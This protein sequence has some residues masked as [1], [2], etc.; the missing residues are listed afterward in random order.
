MGVVED[1]SR[2]ADRLSEADAVSLISHIDAD[3]ITSYSII[4]QALTREGIPV[5][6]DVILWIAIPGIISGVFYWK[7]WHV[8]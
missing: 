5:K 3:G 7:K 4:S 6:P 8:R 2:A 1:V